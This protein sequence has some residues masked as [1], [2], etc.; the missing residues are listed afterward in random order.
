M[1]L[2]PAQLDEFKAE[3]ALAIPGLVPSDVLDGWQAQIRTACSND[4]VDID[5]P[6][7]WP[8][9]RYAP[10]GSWPEFSPI[11]YELETLQSIVEQ[12]GDGAFALRPGGAA[13]VD[14]GTD[15]AGDPAERPGHGVGPPG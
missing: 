11:L 1:Q 13:V 3:G 14:A 9:G 8:T 4:G 5:D 10:A 7:T 15:D 12:I 6:S 2:S